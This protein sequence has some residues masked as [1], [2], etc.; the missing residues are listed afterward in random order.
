MS[1]CGNCHYNWHSDEECNY[2]C[3]YQ[4]A[5]Y[6]E[7]MAYDSLREEYDALVKRYDELYD[8]CKTGGYPMPFSIEPYTEAESKTRDTIV[9]MFW[10][11]RDWIAYHEEIKPTMEALNALANAGEVYP[12][13]AEEAA[14]ALE[15]AEQKI[16]DASGISKEDLNGDISF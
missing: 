3:T 12:I 10:T 8:W 16:I 7:Q 6:R 14:A 4:D 15:I 9:P 1:I 2:D 13:S 5:V 11:R